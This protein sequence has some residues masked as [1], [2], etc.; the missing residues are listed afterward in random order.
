MGRQGESNLS[1]PQMTCVRSRSTTIHGSKKPF[2]RHGDWYTVESVEF[3]IAGHDAELCKK[4]LTYDSKE[5]ESFM[6]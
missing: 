2:C 1:V 6:H 3:N 4:T 5:P